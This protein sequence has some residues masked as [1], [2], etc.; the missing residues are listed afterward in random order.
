MEEKEEIICDI[1]DG[2]IREALPGYY[3]FKNEIWT[4]HICICKKC[5]DKIAGVK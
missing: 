3:R 2:E 5:R 4:V 1:C